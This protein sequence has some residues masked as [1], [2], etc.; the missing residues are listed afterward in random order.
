VIDFIPIVLVVLVMVGWR[1]GMHFIDTQRIEAAAAGRGWR[2]VSVSW[3]PL[4][5]GWMFER[6]ERHY[7]VFYVDRDGRRGEAS[8]KTS[9]LTG[10]FWRDESA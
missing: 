2:D 6:G 3:Q 5:A 7:Q 4:A 8:C 10:V 1:V 9:L